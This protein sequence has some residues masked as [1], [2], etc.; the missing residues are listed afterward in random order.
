MSNRILSPRYWWN[1]EKG[2]DRAEYVVGFICAV[3]AV[4]VAVLGDSLFAQVS[5]L[6]AA[7]GA[8]LGGGAV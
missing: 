2:Q 5:T 8:W 7:I 6:A 3:V 4:A 1:L